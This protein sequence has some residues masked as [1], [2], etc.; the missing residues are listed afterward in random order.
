[1]RIEITWGHGE[2]ISIH[3]CLLS[4]YREFV[5]DPVIAE[6]PARRH[7]CHGRIWQSALSWKGRWPDEVAWATAS[8]DSS[9]AA[10][11]T[12]IEAAVHCEFVAGNDID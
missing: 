3:V 8:R 6:R 1:M 7:R 10:A 5:A 11:V 12:I 4:D 9:R 2:K